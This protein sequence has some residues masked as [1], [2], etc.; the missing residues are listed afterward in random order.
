MFNIKKRLQKKSQRILP[1]YEMIDEEHLF[2]M[3][4][5]IINKHTSINQSLIE[6][7]LSKQGADLATTVLYQYLI[8]KHQDFIQSLNQSFNTVT[9]S[10]RQTFII[11]PALLHDLYPS[12]GGKGQL[13]GNICEKYGHHVHYLNTGGGIKIA[14]TSALI[15]DALEQYKNDDV[16]LISI[17]RGTLDVLNYFATDNVLSK[18]IKGWINISGVTKGTPLA[19]QMLSTVLSRLKMRVICKICQVDYAAFYEMKTTNHHLIDNISFL[20]K[21]KIMSIIGFPLRSHIPPYLLSRYVKLSNIAPNDGIVLLTDYLHFPGDIYPLWG[22]DHFFR[23]P[24]I[25]GIVH[26]IM[27]YIE[28]MQHE[29]K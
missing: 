2:D 27:N 3:A 5:P 21:M 8:N 14:K 23:L 16:W 25:S 12:L 19:D 24:R 26:K 1:K 6:N 15:A 29:K 9:T 17:S 22:S 13:F 7:I 4:L 11:I 20:N 28:C 10:K 18:N